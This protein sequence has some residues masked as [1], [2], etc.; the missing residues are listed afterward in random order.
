VLL[1]FSLGYLDEP[2]RRLLESYGNEFD[3]INLGF[4]EMAMLLLLGGLL[5]LLGALFSV[6]R[7]L[8]LIRIGLKI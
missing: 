2:L 4:S 8:R 3:M 7:H 1:R 5:G 6:Q